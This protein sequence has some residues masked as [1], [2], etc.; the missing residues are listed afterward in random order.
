MNKLCSII[1]A[2]VFP[3]MVVL[4]SLGAV[5]FD[6]SFFMEELNNN[7]VSA[8]TGILTSEYDSLTD[9]IMD[10]LLGIREDV[11]LHAEMADDMYVPIFTEDEQRHMQDVRNLVQV[12]LI[13]DGA[14]AVLFV[15][16]AIFLLIKS[17]RS[18]LKGLFFGT[19]IAIILVGAIAVAAT[20]NFTQAFVVLH[21]IIFNNDLWLLD[22]DTSILISIVPEPYFIHVAMR[23]G[24]I[25]GIILGVVL[26]LSGIGL[27]AT[28]KNA[29]HGT[30]KRKNNRKF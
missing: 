27:F 28:R 30:I 14:C 24:I 1:L 26:I 3:I 18:L 9:D 10:Y 6:R 23:T 29:G 2:I 21:E 4:S 16:T 5:V 19:L 8:N 17:R 11:N 20:L 25:G 22:P 13:V 7:Q 12:A 15:L